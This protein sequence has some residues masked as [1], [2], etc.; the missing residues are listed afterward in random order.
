MWLRLDL[1]STVT[2]PW[3]SA[4]IPCLRKKQKSGVPAFANPAAHLLGDSTA[5]W[6]TSH[7]L[8]GFPYVY[9]M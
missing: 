9:S 3:P 8:S 7:V 1:P 6:L 2:I 5:G 4:A